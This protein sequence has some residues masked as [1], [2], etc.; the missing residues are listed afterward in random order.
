MRFITILL[1]V[2]RLNLL[3]GQITDDFSDGDFKSNPEWAGDTSDF[4]VISD[5]LFLDAPQI[6][7]TSILFLISNISVKAEWNIKVGLNFN[8]SSSNFARVYLMSDNTDFRKN[9]NGYYLKIGGTNDDVSLYRQDQNNHSLIIEGRKGKLNLNQNDLR[10]KISRDSN[11]LWSLES[12][13]TG[14]YD[15]LFEGMAVDSIHLHSIAIGIFCKYTSTRSDKFYFDDLFVNG[16]QYLDDIPPSI[17]HDSITSSNSW[18]VYFNESLD[19]S[20]F[21]STYFNHPE[22]K[23]SEIN[24]DSSLNCLNLIFNTNFNHGEII[25][26]KV[27]SLR[28]LSGNI[29]ISRLLKNLY[30]CPD[31]FKIKDIVINELMPDPDPAVGLPQSEYIE[32]FNRTDDYINL[33]DWKIA[34]LSD[35]ASLPDYILHPKSYIVLIQEKDSAIWVE[36]KVPTI[37]LNLPTLNNSEDRFILISPKDYA[38]DSVRYNVNQFIEEKQNGGWSLELVNPNFICYNNSN[39]KASIDISGGSPGQINSLNDIDTGIDLIQFEKII[40]YSD[41]GLKIQLSAPLN[42]VSVLPENIYLF[43]E[44]NIKEIRLSDNIMNIKINKQFTENKEYEIS[45]LS[46]RNCYNELID[47]ISFS[48]VYPAKIQPGD[49]VINEILFNPYSGGSDF[50][51]IYNVSESYLNITELSILNHL[52]DTVKLFDPLKRAPEILVP[53]QYMAFTEDSADI[54]NRY[55]SS[56][57]INVRNAKLASMP[58]KNGSITL[59]NQSLQLIDVIAYDESMHFP[60]IENVDGKS[61][62]RINFNKSS[63]SRDNWTT[64]SE[65]SGFATPGIKNSHYIVGGNNHFEAVPGI[66]SPDNDGYNDLTK[67]EYHTSES[68]FTG[69][70]TIYSSTG[71]PIRKLVENKLLSDSDFIIWDG[72]NDEL[73]KV[74]NGYYLIILEITMRD[75]TVKTEKTTVV[76]ASK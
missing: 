46:S 45:L 38:I 31:S 44:K 55:I 53:G 20:Y 2:F 7:D 41:S 23:V 75:G 17:T 37:S 59:L 29:L 68:G 64:A 57:P 21:Q 73:Q 1:F 71:Y 12:D 39:W 69:S 70:L 67:I 24:Y 33:K 19:E 43:P 65:T 61:L 11:Y 54:V 13:S 4:Q 18:S 50:I 15:Y 35:T 72:T 52:S 63:S 48:F 28:D 56:D 62:E 22:Y 27:D 36:Y 10:I 25:E 40:S 47:L 8:P 3:L 32:L 76:V 34:D 14:G 26:L 16:T 5:I 74:E 9:L 51:E 58:D 42:P 66:F 49:L 30:N 60:L 6:S